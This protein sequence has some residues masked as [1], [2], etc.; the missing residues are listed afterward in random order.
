MKTAKN[1][2]PRISIKLNPQFSVSSPSFDNF[3]LVYQH[4]AENFSGGE[5]QI[6][7]GQAPL[8]VYLIDQ[9]LVLVTGLPIHCKALYMQMPNFGTSTITHS[10][11]CD[12]LAHLTKIDTLQTLFKGNMPLNVMKIKLW[13]SLL[14]Y[15]YQMLLPGHFLLNH[16]ALISRQTRNRA[17]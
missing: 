15:Y 1:N 5:L 17:K 3:L 13:F 16:E 11:L 14:C 10:N 12:R 2:Q 9:E 8:Q 6:D 7:L 4:E